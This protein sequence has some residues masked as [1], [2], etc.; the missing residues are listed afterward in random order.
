MREVYDT[1]FFVGYFYTSDEKLLKKMKEDLRRTRD[2]YI[3]VITIHEVY[4]LTLA[5][6]GRK[7]AKS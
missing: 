7:A 4:N 1:R 3:S 6:E 5:K 2:R